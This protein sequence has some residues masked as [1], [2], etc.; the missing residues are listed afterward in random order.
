MDADKEKDKAVSVAV[1]QIEKQFGK[2]A[3]MRL[4]AEVQPAEVLPVLL[5]LQVRL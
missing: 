5:L 2:G 1:T 4:G 3:I